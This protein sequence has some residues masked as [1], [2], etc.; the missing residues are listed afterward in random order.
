MIN[1]Q[2]PN[3]TVEVL[4]WSKINPAIP[5]KKHSFFTYVYVC[6]LCVGMHTCMCGCQ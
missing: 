4:A 2:L 1:T 5:L 6:M 3:V